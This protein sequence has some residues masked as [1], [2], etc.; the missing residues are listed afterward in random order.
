ME[1]MKKN[2]GILAVVLLTVLAIQFVS[3]VAPVIA[4]TSPVTFTNYSTTM[5]VAITNTLVNSTDGKYNVTLYC[6]KSG[7]GTT[8]ITAHLITTIWNATAFASSFT[9]TV[10][11]TGSQ[12]GINWNCSAFADNGTQTAAGTGWSVA[13]IK[14]IT[15]DST[16]PVCSISKTYPTIHKDGPQTVTW[17]VTD[18]LSLLSNSE[19]ITRPSP[20]SQITDANAVATYTWNQANTSYLGTWYLNAYGIDMAGNT[21]NAT[22]TFL[23][24]QAGGTVTVPGTTTGTNNTKTILILAGIGLVLWLVFKKK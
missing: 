11:L 21:C 7:G 4:I 13:S 16:S 5:S 24:D 1:K 22:T 23:V 14:N 2:L 8:N 6:N 18:A 20:G 19:A 12:D 3:A 15:F 17:S 10:T 9:K